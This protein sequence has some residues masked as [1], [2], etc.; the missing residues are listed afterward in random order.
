VSKDL[1][2]N[3]VFVSFGERV[4]LLNKSHDTVGQ[5]APKGQRRPQEV[6]TR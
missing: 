6:R 2:L 3:K 1:D 5:E 4:L